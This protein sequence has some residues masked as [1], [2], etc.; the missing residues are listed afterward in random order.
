MKERIEEL[1]QEIEQLK[2]QKMQDIE[3]YRIKLLGKKGSVTKLFEDFREILPEQKR[4]FGQKLNVLKTK[5]A[6]KIEELRQKVEEMG[7]SDAPSFDCTKPGDKFDLGTR[8]PISITREE[9]I[10]CISLS[11]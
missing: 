3:E 4:E 1:L 2:A 8:H 10:S 11:I 7:G 5:A 9:I 6:E